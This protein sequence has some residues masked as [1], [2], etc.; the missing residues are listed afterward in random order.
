MTGARL[1][2]LGAEPDDRLLGEFHRLVL[3]PSFA[4]DELD[5]VATLA[6]GLRGGGATDVRA[7]VA[8]DDR[9]AVVAGIVGE[10]F[11]GT[12]VLLISYLA[13]R[14]DRRGRGLGSRLMDEVASRWYR[15][16][17]VLLV[18]G[19]AHDPRC[20][21]E[22]ADEH[23]T[24][25][26]RLYDRLGARVLAVPFIQ[27]ALEPGSS[28]VPGFLLLAFHVAPQVLEDRGDGPTIPASLVLGFVREYYEVAEG[29]APPDDRGRAA[30]E[31]DIRHMGSIRVLPLAEYRRVPCPQP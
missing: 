4:V 7:T 18:V 14:P 25:R 20:W 23:P 31:D 10:G 29:P 12:G 21:P 16:P 27:P 30:L 3:S 11:R 8:L 19:E 24:D 1:R 22:T 17:G 13:V 5:P 28:R 9:G 15:E 6:S 2:D 26:L